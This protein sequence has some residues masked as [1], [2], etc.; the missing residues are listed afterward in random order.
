MTYIREL[1][2]LAPATTVKVSGGADKAP[3][4]T[5]TQTSREAVSV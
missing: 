1:T 4:W 5:F 2:S 3:N